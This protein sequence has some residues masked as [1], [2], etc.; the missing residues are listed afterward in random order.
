VQLLQVIPP[1]GQT[2]PWTNTAPQ[3]GRANIEAENCDEKRVAV[4]E[5]SEG[6]GKQL[7]GVANDAWARYGNVDF[8]T[9]AP[10]M[11]Q[12]RAS[13]DASAGG[14]VE[15]RT[16]SRTGTLIGTVALT[17]TGSWTTYADFTA[18]LTPVTGAHDV[19]LVFKAGAGKA[20]VGNV[21]WFKLR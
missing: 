20:F 2:F 3:D 10:T 17:S 7:G 6:G 21:N 16:G 13:V 19:F 1:G 15:V 14:T 18:A 11:V 4:I 12:V 5:A 8:G 9:T